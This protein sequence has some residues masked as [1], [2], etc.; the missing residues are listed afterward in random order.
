[1]YIRNNITFYFGTKM[2]LNNDFWYNN[3][4]EYWRT[5][6]NKLTNFMLINAGIIFLFGGWGINTII[7]GIIL[8]TGLMIKL[9]HKK[10][11]D[12]LK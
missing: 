10:Y 7:S 8:L 12:E 6:Y 11:R 3:D 5:K 4:P 1:M 2:K 9:S